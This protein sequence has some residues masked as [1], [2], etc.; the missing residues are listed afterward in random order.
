[1]GY[2]GCGKSHVGKQLA[3]LLNRPFLDTDTMI[4]E[5]S[6]RTISQIF[7]EKGEPEFR[8]LEKNIIKQVSR[9]QDHVISL[10]GG[11]VLDKENWKYISMSGITITLSCPPEVILSRLADKRDRPLLNDKQDQERLNR[12][13][14]ML[15]Q[16]QPFYNRADIVIHFNHVIPVDAMAQM[17]LT[18]CGAAT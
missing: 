12:I 5:K 14:E 17:L 10:G 6:K 4:E 11:A 18:Y 13:K 3:E 1:M 9:L 2:M 8:L 16:R 7:E 15:D